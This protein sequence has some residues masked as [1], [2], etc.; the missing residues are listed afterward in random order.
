MDD[1]KL[2]AKNMEEMETLIQAVKI[3]RQGTEMEF[4][5]EKYAMI[6]MK[7]KKCHL[8]EGI[9]LPNQDKTRMLEETETY[10]YLRILEPLKMR[11]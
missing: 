8:T 5:R 11:R 2:F 3:Y 7:T 1:I 4:A 10:K 6:M 9:E